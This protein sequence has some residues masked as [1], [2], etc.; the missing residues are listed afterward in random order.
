MTADSL[1]SSNNISDK[2][3][4][5]STTKVYLNLTD[6]QNQMTTITQ[7]PSLYSGNLTIKEEYQ[8]VIRPLSTLEYHSLKQSI[9]QDP[10]PFVLIHVNENLTILDG[11]HRWRICQEE[12]ITPYIRVNILNGDTLA[13]KNFI[14]QHNIARRQLGDHEKY[15]YGYDILK[16]EEEKARGRQIELA[17][18]RKKDDDIT[19]VPIGTKVET[20]RSAEIVAKQ[21]GG[22]TRTFQRYIYALENGSEEL[23]QKL[24]QGEITPFNACNQ[25]KNQ[26]IIDEML[27]AA[28]N[29]TLPNGVKLIPGD[30]REVSK[31][32]PDNS[33]DAI[34]TDPP[35]AEK[36][37]PL[38][39]SLGE[40][41]FTVL[42]PGG[43]LVMYASEYQLKN[44]S[45]CALHVILDY[46][47]HSGLK[48]NGIITIEHTG[49][50]RIIQPFIMDCKHLLWYIKGDKSKIPGVIMSNLIKSQ[51]SEKQFHPWE[52]SLV[53]AE[54]CISKLTVEN[55][56]ILDPMG[57]SGTTLLA[58]LNLK[59][60]AIGIDIDPQAIEISEARIT[61][62]F[63]SDYNNDGV[64]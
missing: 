38:Y 10:E 7:E 47:Q 36:D 63:S 19:L 48:E 17:G 62:A 40:L 64:V 43:S 23:K 8:H 55:D 60:Q 32:I 42:K 5:I 12:G 11:Y 59:R 46:M 33:V 9:L 57:G 58:A 21:I 50:T 13:E 1:R 27:S 39:K 35:Y 25:I 34:V 16:T 20:G 61:G 6:R 53:E 18:T 31:R 51:P 45:R 3:P 4:I 44:E 28:K 52:Q 14:L 30:F 41:A 29:C 22:K 54:Y 49:H 56:I 24:R 26:K 37:L 15:A 2:K